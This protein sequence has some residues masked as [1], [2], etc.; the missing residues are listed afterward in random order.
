MNAFREKESLNV[1]S[2]SFTS[3]SYLMMTVV[4][5]F[6]FFFFVKDVVFVE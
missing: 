4:F 2:P 5:F 3:S 1:F 6:F